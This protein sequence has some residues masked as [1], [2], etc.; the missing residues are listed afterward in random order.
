[1][2]PEPGVP[3]LRNS[4]F[5]F[6]NPKKFDYQGAMGV[7]DFALWLNDELVLALTAGFATGGSFEIE[8]SGPER[9]KFLQFTAKYIPDYDSVGSYGSFISLQELYTGLWVKSAFGMGGPY[10]RPNR[11]IFWN[12][13]SGNVNSLIFKE[14]FNDIKFIGMSVNL[15]SFEKV[16]LQANILNYWS[17]CDSQTLDLEQY[18]DNKLFVSGVSQIMSAQLPRHLGLEI[19]LVASM[20]LTYLSAF[21]SWAVFFPGERYY[22]SLLAPLDY[23]DAY[24]VLTCIENRQDLVCDDFLNATDITKFNPSYLF[25]AGFSYTF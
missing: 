22:S 16:S 11:S 1:L 9:K 20:D 3:L 15:Y 13:N 17:F 7:A 19:F 14:L 23:F 2:P 25:S 6:F 12:F 18:I 24:Y 5:R 21:I 10:P 8:Q 4:S